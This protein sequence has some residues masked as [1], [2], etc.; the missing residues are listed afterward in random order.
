MK[1]VILMTACTL[2]F[3]AGAAIA[4]D[5]CNTTCS[6]AGCPNSEMVMVGAS[7]EMGGNSWANG[8]DSSAAA[9]GLG[10]VNVKY[11]DMENG[12][13][14]EFHG[15]TGYSGASEGSGAISA[16]GDAYQKFEFQKMDTWGKT[17]CTDGCVNT[18]GWYDVTKVN[19]VAENGATAYGKENAYAFEAGQMLGNVVLGNPEDGNSA[20]FNHVY[21]SESEGP[22]SAAA[23]G[24]ADFAA[25]FMK[26]D[27]HSSSRSN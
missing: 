6:G 8:A 24:G 13:G 21:G 9:L 11:G 27:I 23:Y 17:E 14:A 15:L 4:C 18:E 1:K 25:K 26:Y 22:D 3:F 5:D 12:D 2:T 19:A 20:Q 7:L 16:G 10:E